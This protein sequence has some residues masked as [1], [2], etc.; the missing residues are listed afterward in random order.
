MSQEFTI[1]NITFYRLFLW[2]SVIALIYF[3]K[4]LL[5]MLVIGIFFAVILEV[6]IQK[7]LNKKFFIF[8]YNFTVSR[9]SATALIFGLGMFI[10]F[11]FF[12]KIMP[13]IYNQLFELYHNLYIKLL[14]NTKTNIHFIDKTNIV[15]YIKS[16]IAQAINMEVISKVFNTTK[17]SMNFIFYVVSNIFGGIINFLLITIFTFYFCLEDK[18]VERLIKTISPVNRAKTFVNIWNRAQN[19]I[20]NWAEGQF[21]SASIIAIIVFVCLFVIKMPYA[22]IFALLSLFGQM[23]PLVGILLSSIPAI[24]VAFLFVD[25]QFAIIVAI[26]FFIISQIESYVVYPKVMDNKVGVPAL[27]VL[28][29]ILVGVKLL[30]FWGV[31]LAVPIVAV[32]IE[33][34]KDLA[35]HKNI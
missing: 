8:K 14:E 6:P 18:G 25:I 9:T 15:N 29:S 3:F 35:K 33:M 12:Y 30:G 31:V 5:L 22:F 24:I 27:F 26:I 19:K 16:E 20:Q 17:E 32:I 11:L 7:L 2:L 21:I 28:I 10:V 34:M 4:D 23:I 13:I 1:S